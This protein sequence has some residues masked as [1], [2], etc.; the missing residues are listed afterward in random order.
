[1]PAL[2]WERIPVRAELFGVERLE[3][4][5]R[6]LAAAQPVMAGRTRDSRLADRL[7]DNAAFLLQANG[8]LAK[9]AE[10]GYHA[11]PAAEWLADNYHLVDM[12]IREIGIDLPPGFYAQLPKLAAGPFT[13]LPRLFEAMWSLVAHSDSHLEIEAL[14]R[15]LVAFQSLQPLTIGELWA[16]PITLRIVLIENLRRIAELVMEDAGA[17]QAADDIA[18]RMQDVDSPIPNLPGELV[19]SDPFAVQLAHRLRGH[20]PRT[21]PLLAWLDRRLEAQGTTVAGVVHDELQKQGMANATVRNIITSLRMIAGMDWTDLFERVSLVDTVLASAGPFASMDFNTRN[22]YRTAIEVLSRGS[23]FSELDIA[24]KAASE[25]GEH[26]G[27]RKGDPGYYLVGGG[28]RGFKAAIGYRPTLRASLEHRCRSLGIGGY[29]AVVVALALAFV[30]VPLW[31]AAEAGAGALWLALLGAG[32]FVLASDAAM[33]CMNRLATWAFG[34]TALP[35]L[36]LEAGI[37]APLRTLVAV[38]I[39]LTTAAAV[40]DQLARLELHHLASRDGEVHFA[41]LSDW[42]D[43]AAEHAGTDAVLLGAATSGIARLNRLY[44][45]APGGDR[46]LLLHRRR[47]W[48]AGEARWIGWERKRGKLHEL[49]RLLRGASDTTFLNPPPVPADIRYVVT[50][51]ADTRL[52]HGAVRRMVGKMAHPL[53]APRLDPLCGRIVEGHAVLQPRVTPSL[54]T[55]CG[56]TV[57][58]RI[59]SSMDGI[60]PYAGAVSDVYQD[61]F[62]EGSFA[63]KGI[64]DVDAFDAALKGRVADS[65]LLSHDLFEGVFARAGLA[66]DIEVVEEFPAGYAVAA[67]RQH[68]WARGDWQLLPWIA[69]RNGRTARD[70][71]PAMG[72]WK[73]LDNLRRS[74]SAPAGVTVL[75]AGWVLPFPAALAWTAFVLLTIA[76]P[77]LLPVFGD[78][79]PGTRWVTLRSY[80][81]VLA[82][83]MRHAAALSG[84]VVVFLA[85]QSVLMSDA[86]GRTVIRVYWTRRHLLQWVTAA[87]AADGPALGVT[88][89]YW[90]MAGAPLLGALALAVA[91]WSR[92]GSWVLAAPFAAAWI[93]SPAVAYWASRVPAGSCPL[94]SDGDRRAL[95]QTAR[96]TW[97]FFETFVTSADNM[98]PPDN[99]QED[100]APVL[101]RRTSPTNIGLYLLST[102]AAH[103]FGWTGL[104]DTVERLEATLATMARLPRLRGHFY[105]WYDTADLRPLEP[106]YVS[107]VDSGNLAGH[108][109]TLANACGAWQVC[110]AGKAPYRA[111]LADTAGI[112]AEEVARLSAAGTPPRG[113]QDVGAALAVITT[114][115]AQAPVGD[116]SAALANLAVDTAAAGGLAKALQAGQPDAGDLG[117]WITAL[118]QSVESHRRD[119]AS[120]A[121]LAPRLLA[122]EQTVRD[123]ALAMEFGFLRNRE[124]KLLSIGFLAEEGALDTNCYDLLA[125]EARLACFIGIAKGDIPAREWFRLG[126]AVTPM[127]GG[128]V[129]VSWSGSMFE[130]LMPSLVMRAPEGSLLEDTSQLV[131]RRQIGFGADHDVPW[132]IS[133]SAYNVRDVKYTY[134]Y[135]NFGIPGLGLKRGLDADMV[136]A[137]Y[138]TALAAMVDPGAAVANLVRLAAAGGQGRYGFYEALDYTPSRIPAGKTMAVVRAFMA[139]HQGMTVIAIADAVLDGVMRSRFHAEPIIQATELLLQERAP[140]N[141]AVARPLPMDVNPLV[142]KAVGPPGGRRYTGADSPEPVTHL[143]SNGRYAVMLTATGGGISRWGDLAVTRWRE[144]PT[145][146]DWGAWI[147][148]RDAGS[149]KVW[150][151]GLQPIGVAPDEYEVAFGEDRAEFARRDGTLTTIMEV[152]VSAEEDAEVRRIS[153]SNA[154]PAARTIDIT[155][156]AELAMIC[157]ADDIAHPAFAK[158]FVQTERLDDAILATRRRRTPNEPEIWAAHLLVAEG[159]V[160]GGIEAETDRACFLGRG[161]SLRDAAAMAGE[162]LSNTTGTVLDAV[163]ALRCR[164]TVAPG[165]VIHVAFW[166]MVADSRDA[167][168]GAMDKHRDAAAFDR[169]STLAWTQAQVQLRH[170]GIRPTEADLFQ[171]L[172]GHLVFA[173]PALRPGSQSI[174][175]GS[176]PQ[177]RLWGQGISGDLPIL[178]L[179]IRDSADLE[180]AR[181]VLRAHEYFRLKQLA[182]DL[183][184]LNEHAA[185]YSQD[186]QIALEALVRMQP[187]RPPVAGAAAQG[188]IF[189]LRADLIPDETTALLASAARV[190]LSAEWG[191]LSEQIRE[192]AAGV[193]PVP[194]P[195]ASGDPG[196]AIPPV[197]P[198]EFFN[199]HGGFAEDGREYVVVLRPGQSTPAPWINVIANPGFGFLVAAEGGGYTWSRN[200]R[201]NQLT[202]WSNDP[203][204]NRSGEAF[205]LRD[206]DTQDL[207]CPTALPRRDAGATYVARHGRGFSR[208][209]RVAYGIASSL[210]QYV[211]TDDPV[212][213]SRLHLHNLSGRARTLCVSA[214]VEWVLGASRTATAAFVATEMDDETGAMLARN[215]WGATNAGRVAFADLGGQQT[216]WT[217]DRR[218]FIGRHG[219]LNCP[220]GAAGTATLSGRVGAGLDPCGAM[221]ATIHLAPGARA[222]I[223]F[224]LGEAANEGEARALVAKYRAADLDAVLDGVRLLWEGVL[225]A[226]EVR[227]PDRSMDILL[228]G[229]LLYQALACRVWARAGFYQASGAYGFRDQLQDGMALTAS[230]PDLV[231]EHLLR[232]A[233]RQFVEGDVQHWWLPESGMGVRTRI[234]DDCAWLATAVAH[235]VEAT[236]DD[237]VLEENIGFLDAPVLKEAEHDRFFTPAAADEGGTLFEHCARALDHSLATG[238]HGLPLMGTGD[239]NDGMSRIGEAGRGESVWLGWFLHA[240]LLAF[241]PLAE[242]R[243]DIRAA[244]WRAHAAALQPALEAA[245]DGQWYLRA[246]YDDGTPLGSHNDAECRI[247]SI[248]QS[249]AVLSGVAP[250]DRAAAAMASLGRELVRSDDGLVLVLTPPFD[251][252]SHDPGYIKGY[253]PGLRENG[254]QYTHAAAWAV[255][256]TAALGDGD[257][258]AMLF[259][260]LNPVRRSLTQDDAE[261]SKVEPYAVV[262]DVYSVPPHVGRGGWSWYTGSA[263]WMQRA[264]VEAI[265]GLRIR[266]ATL[267]ID[268]CIP[269][270]WPGFEATIT[271]RS[272]HYRIVVKN[273]GKLCGGVGSIRLDGAHLTAGPV[274][275]LDDGGTHLVEITLNGKDGP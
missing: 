7:A 214:Y 132:G 216:G 162:T 231:R 42:T 48:N 101:A 275:M 114:R 134:Q 174:Q 71:I 229:W 191:S 205:Y 261:R 272:A 16:V 133:E 97:R 168:A 232:A 124:R 62:G 46:F 15:Y 112:V 220:A 43:S 78:V 61:V 120:T 150:S 143:L 59:F 156:Y 183:V 265:L 169:A 257:G 159:P 215:P 212:K 233:G 189:L 109:I 95:R 76:L 180:V 194:A 184:I 100:P 82:D 41:L 29:G 218:E 73:M 198:L 240:A 226:V 115:L 10:D 248:A 163:F 177:P 90:R 117:F 79:A 165:A 91:A 118:H 238:A 235:Y 157:G 52:P 188:A 267:H 230:R 136:I 34:P 110:A 116:R 236:G 37:S 104:L 106:R 55:G 57:F 69:L 22:L 108:L 81:G 26:K 160:V 208:F 144:D 84:L 85:H 38:P 153:V 255:L 271:W 113:L 24:R 222:E 126:R 266:G 102:V 23:D 87:Q 39:L 242:A 251:R 152:L 32:G 45:K 164:M 4:H 145:L 44:G 167:L 64:Y 223:V 56:S 234:S 161:R 139:H 204:T 249:W 173:G 155:S 105:N 53:N 185:S 148:L 66:S 89:Y 263:G 182:V 58:Q 49:N 6:S 259:G 274:P 18:G 60:D 75:L 246:Y 86:I 186:L 268:P 28:G 125:S 21:N 211:P 130:Y 36:A 256:A 195:P 111:G 213:L 264:G 128:A 83:A 207:W 270:D 137:P 149:G 206:A 190:V 158:M 14:R 187:H 262:A 98:L 142:A 25:A 47:V 250:P 227:T 70:A 176:G 54:P 121:E 269:H 273:P 27:G 2:S 192:R 219:S 196:T 166:T 172:A 244:A 199:G 30:A 12:Q 146:D 19:V 17:R 241:A 1:M 209:D 200:S 210:V 123:M 151:A 171:R 178:L 260:L 193:S 225:G 140:R 107:T 119:P 147:L 224:L 129:L 67:L 170:L 131:V 72:R 63:G 141:V 99:F 74:L 253:P 181:Q 122:I 175:R 92:T 258:A 245:W 51:D 31:V 243:N 20:D 40:A 88:G 127:A 13:G 138:A 252:T 228:N 77:A 221:Q 154:G 202:P 96:R 217:G 8:A 201:E 239:W 80:L 50:L 254:G 9:S 103:D 179:R 65:T 5:A 33:A 135:S 3:Q 203:V 94:V 237:A 35:G 247:D 11:T 197:P 68:R 93:A